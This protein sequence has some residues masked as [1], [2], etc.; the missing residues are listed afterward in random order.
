MVIKEGNDKEETI[1]GVYFI[2][3]NGHGE[4]QE[5]TGAGAILNIRAAK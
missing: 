1:R 5:V 4:D 3:I 2:N